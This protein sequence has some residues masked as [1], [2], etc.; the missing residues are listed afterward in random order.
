MECDGL[1]R[2]AGVARI[3]VHFVANSASSG[4]SVQPE[5]R[6]PRY[7][8]HRLQRQQ[9]RTV[10]SARDNHMSS[11][12]GRATSPPSMSRHTVD[13]AKTLFHELDSGLRSRTETT[14]DARPMTV[15]GRPDRRSR[16]RTRPADERAAQG[17]AEWYLRRAASAGG[18]DTTRRSLVTT[19]GGAGGLGGYSSGDDSAD[20]DGNNVTS[21]ACSTSTRSPGQNRSSL[22]SSTHFSEGSV[23]ARCCS[24]CCWLG[25]Y[26]TNTAIDGAASQYT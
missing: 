8:Q 9:Q 23:S 15:A 16:Q 5:V 10:T 7:G 12:N 1:V 11:V 21:Q 25:H 4:R 19:S 26:S 14:V 13:P 22:L 6:Q 18:R 3:P 17:G 20:D 24:C 2:S